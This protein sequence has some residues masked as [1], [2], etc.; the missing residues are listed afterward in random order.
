MGVRIRVRV[1]HVATGRSVTTSAL[2]N[3]G[4][5]ARRPTVRLPVGLARE[6][7]LS[8][9]DIRGAETAEFIVGDGRVASFTLLRDALRISAWPKTGW[10]GQSSPTP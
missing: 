4:F 1:E 6:L 8:E 7:G 2:V 10:R 9:E 3:T 5:E